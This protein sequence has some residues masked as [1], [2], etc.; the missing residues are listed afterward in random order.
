LQDAGCRVAT[1]RAG[2]VLGGGDCATGRLVP[3]ALR[4]YRAN[5]TLELRQP[6][7]VRPWQYVLDVLAGYLLYAQALF[8]G[9]AP[10]AL[11]FGP[12]ADQTMTAM[13][14][15]DRLQQ[16]LGATNG[17]QR[18][19]A[20]YAETMALRLDPG[21][22]MRTLGWQART[23]IDTALDWTVAWHQAMWRGEDMRRVGQA[24]IAAWGAA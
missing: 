10:P 24:Q 15:A 23:D 6:Q 8:R 9:E 21:R 16:K 11:N 20:P 19:E 3:D 4:A 5:R 22:A 2:N 1:A 17:W 7:A 14:L 13:A 12:A 18:G